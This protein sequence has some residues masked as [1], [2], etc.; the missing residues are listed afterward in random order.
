[1]ALAIAGMIIDQRWFDPSLCT[2]GRTARFWFRDD[3]ATLLRSEMLA[4]GGVANGFL[5]WDERRGAPVAY[6]I[7]KCRYTEYTTSANP[8]R[9]S[10]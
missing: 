7:G 2:I 8:N 5:A 6:A 9:V 1:V 10:A 3:D 4:A